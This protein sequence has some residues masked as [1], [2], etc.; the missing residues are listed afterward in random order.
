MSSSQVLQ[1]AQ[2]GVDLL[3]AYGGIEAS[4]LNNTLA[5]IEGRMERRQIARQSAEDAF[6]RSM[7]L[8]EVLAGQ[9]A[10]LAAAGIVGGRTAR[11][12]EVQSRLT[13][14]RAQQAADFRTLTATQ[15]SQF[16]QSRAR[17]VAMMQRAQT[18]VDLFGNL[19]QSADTM[20]QSRE[21]R[22]VMGN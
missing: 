14:Q 7:Q 17:S 21:A 5:Q 11:L 13:A 19:M 6:Q 20:Q 22:S 2:V 3:A 1:Y 16:R 8:R 12:F 10:S 15:A 9:Q 4:R 18:A